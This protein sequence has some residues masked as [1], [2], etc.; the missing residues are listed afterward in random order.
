MTIRAVIGGICLIAIGS[1]A[2]QAQTAAQAPNVPHTDV[3]TVDGTQKTPDTPAPV[4]EV[5]VPPG[6]H[7][8]VI[9]PKAGNDPAMHVDGGKSSSGNQ[10]AEPK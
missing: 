8:D 3:P 2:G 9:K 10:R 4:P 5:V 1:G 7:G 6:Q